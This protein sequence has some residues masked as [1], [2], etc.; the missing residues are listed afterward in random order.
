MF[1]VIAA[2]VSI[3]FWL[4]VF[5]IKTIFSFNVERIIIIPRGFHLFD[6]NFETTFDQQ[7]LLHTHRRHPFPRQG[8]DACGLRLYNRK[9]GDFSGG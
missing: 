5:G 6:S 9:H 4:C 7:C 1:E 2:A 8:I 3:C